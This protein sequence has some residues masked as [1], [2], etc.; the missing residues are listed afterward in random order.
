MTRPMSVRFVSAALLAVASLHGGSTR[1][2]GVRLRPG[3]G[4]YLDAKGAPLSKPEG[5]ACT[6]SSV[7]VAD[8]GNGR[9]VTYALSDGD[10]T[11]Q[12]DFRVPEVP[13]PIRVRL[14]PSG[15]ILALDGKSL[16]IARLTTGGEFRGFVRVD[17]GEGPS[18]VV[19]GFDV[20]ADGTLAIL[21]I[22]SRRV[23]LED[24]SGKLLRSVALSD[25]C[26]FPSDVAL[27]PRGTV[28]VLDAVGAQVYANGKDPAVAAAWGAPLHEDLSFATSLAVDPSGRV[29]VVDQN[30]GGIVILGP[31]GSFR[32]RQSG[33]GWTDGLL[34]WPSS[35]CADG[36]GGLAVADRENDRV[37]TF[38]VAP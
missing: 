27:G 7:V 16:R 22:A 25:A 30:G 32:G 17:S 29:F 36:K 37:A 3:R 13:V 15:E 20:A 6:P 10:A 9:F 26:R 2:E 31:E 35:I 5:V 38:A 33:F 21:D 8:T 28:Y 12:A 24:A 14:S 4:I 11:A 34:R 19:R 23:F 18:P 1:A